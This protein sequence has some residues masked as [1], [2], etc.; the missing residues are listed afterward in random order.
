MSQETLQNSDSA[1]KPYPEAESAAAGQ[2]DKVAEGVAT[3]AVPAKQKLRTPARAI[4]GLAADDEVWAF[5][6][7]NDLLPH[8]ETAIRLVGESFI[9]VREIKLSYEPDPEIPKFNSVA[10]NVKVRG[11]V[12][13][14]FEQYKNYVRAFIRAVS[15]EHSHQI[16][17]LL[18]VI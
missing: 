9:D 6:R 16:D 11:T 7:A 4:A 14:L 2:T 18:S 13:E 15:N 5:V 12:E 1:A 8:L 3:Y 17:L 10:I